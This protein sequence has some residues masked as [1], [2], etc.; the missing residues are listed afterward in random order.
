MPPPSTFR[1]PQGAAGLTK[2]EVES[3]YVGTS[4]NG[5]IFCKTVPVHLGRTRNLPEPP[6]H[7]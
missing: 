1:L 7:A 2:V 4:R 3:N 5:S 6:V